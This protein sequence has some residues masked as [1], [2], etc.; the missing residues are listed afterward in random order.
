MTSFIIEYHRSSGRVSVTDYPTKRAAVEARLRR[1]R[2]GVDR[3]VEIVSVTT[4][5]LETLKHSHS[6]YFLRTP[7]FA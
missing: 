7:E 3:N 4:E 2:E 1:N 6:R 5:S